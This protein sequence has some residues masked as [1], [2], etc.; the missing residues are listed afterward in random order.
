MSLREKVNDKV[1]LV[2][3]FFNFVFIETKPDDPL[4]AYNFSAL[5]VYNANLEYDILLCFTKDSQ[6]VWK[7]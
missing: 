2:F 7:F 4:E 5:L 3:R 6:A 1:N